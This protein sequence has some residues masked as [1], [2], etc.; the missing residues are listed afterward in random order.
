M[1]HE[2]DRPSRWTK[3]PYSAASSRTTRSLEGGHSP[4]SWPEQPAASRGPNG[5]RRASNARPPTLPRIT[6]GRRETQ[7]ESTAPLHLEPWYKKNGPTQKM[8]EPKD[9][10]AAS[11]G[12]NGPRRASNARPPTLPRITP[13]RRETQ[14]ESTAPLHLEPWYKKNG[15]TQKMGEPKDVLAA[16]YSPTG[17]PRQYHPRGRA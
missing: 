16:T 14:W 1:Q 7:W 6:P 4:G 5:P 12:P 11:R 10:L 9:V 3:T 13:G 2:A 15:P 8:G 17:S